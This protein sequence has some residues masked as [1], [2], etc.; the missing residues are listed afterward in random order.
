[1][2]LPT[3]PDTGRE[4]VKVI[5]LSATAALIREWPGLEYPVPSIEGGGNEAGER[6][7]AQLVEVV[8]EEAALAIIRH[9]RGVRLY[10]PNLKAVKNTWE[11][12]HAHQEYERL[13]MAPHRY[14]HDQAICEIALKSGVA[15]RT[16]ERWLERAPIQS[17]ALRQ[18]GAFF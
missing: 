13:C 10:I 17:D 14:T 16:V 11:R 2:E 3:F 9:Y 6:R 5:G 4:L 12:E 18:Q 1:M 7:F 8:G 15:S